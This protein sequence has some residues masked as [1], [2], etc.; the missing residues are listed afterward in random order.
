V[1]SFAFL[2]NPVSGGGVGPA[3]AE[4]VATPLR[5]AGHTVDVTPT[6]DPAQTAALVG[7]AVSSGQVVVSVGGDGMLSS[8]AGSVSA[9]DGVLGIVP[10][11]RGNDFARMLQ[12]SSDPADVAAT[13]GRGTARV[14]DLIRVQ[15]PDQP[16]R[17]VVG[18]AY[19]GLDARAGALVDK[20]RWMPSALQ[21]PAVAIY[22]IATYRASSFHVAADG[23]AF[24]V[25]GSSVVLANSAY[26][27]GGMKIA[28]S[29][30]VDDGWLEIGAMQVTT[31]RR[32]LAGLRKVYK[33]EHTDMPE[34]L[35]R[36]AKRVEITGSPQVL[37][38]GDGESIGRLPALGEPPAVV[39]IMPGALKILT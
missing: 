21:Y 30:A 10:A 31:R 14:V 19:S 28:P 8:V 18:S 12:L 15:L 22:G 13:L 24:D 4:S 17:I 38:A 11:G 9:A 37:I 6:T 3:A 16:E 33:G 32:L 23:E 5:A 36:R 25:F 26:Y 35:S 2:V 20:L 27:G 29:A 34:V 7:H 39:E 1:T